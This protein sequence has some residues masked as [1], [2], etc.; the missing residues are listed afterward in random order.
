MT[1]ARAVLDR[2][3]AGIGW[4]TDIDVIAT[5]RPHPRSHM[6]GTAAWHIATVD[7]RFSSSAGA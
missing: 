4:R 6:A 2:I 5:T 7:S 3:S 1:P